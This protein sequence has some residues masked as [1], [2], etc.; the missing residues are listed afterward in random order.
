MIRHYTR[1]GSGDPRLPDLLDAD[2]VGASLGVSP[3]K[4]YLLARSG[5]LRSVSIGRSVRFHPDDVTTFVEER[6]RNGRTA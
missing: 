1:V 6:R 2:T 3:E 5:E 4:V